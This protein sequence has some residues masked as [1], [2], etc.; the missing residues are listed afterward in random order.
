MVEQIARNTYA[1]LWGSDPVQEEYAER[2]VAS[3]PEQLDTCV[4]ATG[5]T[6]S[7]EEAIKIARAATG[8][9][10]IVGFRSSYHGQLFAAM[11]LGFPP[12]LLAPIAPGVPEFVQLDF[13]R[14]DGSGSE[15]NQFS[16][17]LETVLSNMEVAAFITEPGIV[18]GWGSVWT[19]P[20]GYLSLV[21]NL[22]ERYGTLLVVDEVGTGFSRTGHLFGIGAE[23]V[24]PDL[25]CL[26]KGISNGAAALG[27]VAGK[28]AI[29]AECAESANLTSTF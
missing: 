13:P 14:E 18:T 7:V 2:L 15:L 1:P 21:R 27:A 10:K 19:A 24:V 12:E 4:K 25:V 11:T 20:A 6:E 16:K 5:G 29:I 17:S 26:A 22:T 3:L 28:H 23:G 8:R 9:K